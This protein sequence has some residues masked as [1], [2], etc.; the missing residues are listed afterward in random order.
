M[1]EE[2]WVPKLPIVLVPGFGSTGLEVVQ[3]YEKWKG[4]RVWLSISKIG[5]QAL[6]LR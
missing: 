2:G 4:E 1:A 6:S 5:G 3:G